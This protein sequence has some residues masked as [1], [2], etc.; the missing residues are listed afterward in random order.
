MPLA[1]IRPMNY[2]QFVGMIGNSLW[3]LIGVLE[4]HPIGG[5]CN[6]LQRYQFKGMNH[7]A[8]QNVRIKFHQALT[9]AV[10]LNDRIGVANNILQWGNM[11]PMNDKMRN[12][13]EASLLSLNDEAKGN[14]NH[15]CVERIASISKI[16]E[17]WNPAAWVIYDSY[18]AKGLQW[19]V[20]QFWNQD[21]NELHA[22][23]LKLPWPP[24]RVGA[25]VQ[26]FPRLGTEQQARLAF[27]YASWL[28]RAIAA[29]L[30]ENRNQEL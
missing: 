12:S 25:P 10:K 18:C 6:A 27:I 15:V 28:C 20:S 9:N 8:G 29:R 2:Q 13:L 17:M 3:Q 26:G 11:K 24:G 30:N 14:L 7:V 22:N 5:W 19:L 23:I 1:I 4:N 21:A 16:Y